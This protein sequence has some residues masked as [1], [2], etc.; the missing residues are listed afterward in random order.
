MKWVNCPSI[1]YEK[2]I[3]HRIRLYNQLD[4][5]ASFATS[6]FHQLLQA[7]QSVRSILS[8]ETVFEY[9][10]PLII[11]SGLHCVLRILRGTLNILTGFVFKCLTQHFK[12]GQKFKKQIFKTSEI[13]CSLFD[14]LTFYPNL[15]TINLRLSLVTDITFIINKSIVSILL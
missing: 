7:N 5:L 4:N 2:P 9:G 15:V 6:N 13:L 3:D 10:S 1:N 14:Q 11:D 12:Q 8:Y